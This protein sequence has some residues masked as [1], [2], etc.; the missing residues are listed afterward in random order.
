VQLTVLC[1][2]DK[3]CAKSF[4]TDMKTFRWVFYMQSFHKGF[5]A[6]KFIPTYLNRLW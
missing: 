4:F 5:L 2:T 3:K 6:E 1:D